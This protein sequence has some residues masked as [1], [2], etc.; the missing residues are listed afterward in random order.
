M[1]LSA[2]LAAVWAFA[3]TGPGIT[4]LITL[5]LI[6]W[7]LTTRNK[8]N[9]A[10]YEGLIVSA[11]KLAEKAIPDNSP[12]KHLHRFDTAL[13]EFARQYEASHGKPPTASLV[14]QVANAIP[15]IHDRIAANGT[16]AG[17]KPPVARI[18]ERAIHATANLPPSERPVSSN[19]ETEAITK[20][21]A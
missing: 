11:I 6:A 9:L 3:Q 4:L 16:L 7:N 13:R 5:I 21:A 8:P 17:S 19:A 20:P 15:L 2:I 1:N 10:S 14:S 18:P 12:N